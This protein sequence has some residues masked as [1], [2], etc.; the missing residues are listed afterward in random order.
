VFAVACV[1]FSITGLLILQVHAANRPAVWPTVGL[2]VLIPVLI[3]LLFI[4]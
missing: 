2:G 1:V 4:H 3:A